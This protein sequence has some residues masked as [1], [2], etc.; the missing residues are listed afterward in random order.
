MSGRLFL[1]FGGEEEGDA[2]GITIACTEWWCLQDP[3][4][5]D[6]VQKGK[7]EGEM[8]LKDSPPLCK[9]GGHEMQH[10]SP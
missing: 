7:A 1:F 5:P 4:I 3:N 6:E 2:G 8:F 10:D 9:I